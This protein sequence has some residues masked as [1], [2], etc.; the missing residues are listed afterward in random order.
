MD[1]FRT[2]GFAV[3]LAI[4][5]VLTTYRQRDPERF[6]SAY[7]AALTIVLLFVAWMMIP[8]VRAFA[9]MLTHQTR[10]SRRITAQ[11]GKL[12]ATDLQAAY[13]RARIVTPNA[14]LRCTRAESDW[15]YVCSYMPTP[16]QSK[17]RLAFGVVVDETRVLQTSRPVPEGTSLPSPH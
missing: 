2:I 15:D 10:E 3:N 1:W 5:V 16:L 17:A 11:L 6:T 12:S 8:H 9:D 13:L 14:G 4:F 7:R